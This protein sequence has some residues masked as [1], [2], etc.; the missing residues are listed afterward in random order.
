MPS[1]NAG[2]CQLFFSSATENSSHGAAGQFLLSCV[3]TLLYPPLEFFPKALPEAGRCQGL[4]AHGWHNASASEDAVQSW[5][6]MASPKPVTSL[7]K[8]DSGLPEDKSKVTL[9]LLAAFFCPVQCGAGSGCDGEV[10]GTAQPRFR[11]SS[12]HKSI[13]S[14]KIGIMVTATLLSLVLCARPLLSQTQRVFPPWISLNLHLQFYK[15]T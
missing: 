15:R 1:P 2:C 10:L 6:S 7:S 3:F 5:Y 12:A 11:S 4:A 8:S 14:Q 9:L 13:L